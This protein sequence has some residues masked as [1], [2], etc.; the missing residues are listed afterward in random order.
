[1]SEK[2]GNTPCRQEAH[3]QVRPLQIIGAANTVKQRAARR[4]ILAC[5]EIQGDT[6]RVTQATG[7]DVD[8][9]SLYGLPCFCS[10]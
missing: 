2:W 4:G 6:G 10:E 8:S 5:L 3:A 7:F 1:M 9:E